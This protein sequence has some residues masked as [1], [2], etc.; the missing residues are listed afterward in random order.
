MR[1]IMSI[2]VFTLIVLNSIINI[3]YVLAFKRES[4]HNSTDK[5]IQQKSKQNIQCSVNAN[6]N[7]Q[8]LNNNKPLVKIF[9]VMSMPNAITI[10]IPIWW[11][12]KNAPYVYF[13]MMD[14]SD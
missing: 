7:N 1:N 5:Y 11:F 12:A 13:N 6:C 3:N 9:N 10:P 14:H 2:L 4:I 8:A